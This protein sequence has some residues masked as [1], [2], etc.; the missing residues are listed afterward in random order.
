MERK[1]LEDTDEA[2]MVLQTFCKGKL[3]RKMLLKNLVRN[4]TQDD[5]DR[6]R[7]EF[8]PQV[9]TRLQGEMAQ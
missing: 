2:I 5:I 8:R 9:I 4:V 1:M 3:N 7:A 6:L